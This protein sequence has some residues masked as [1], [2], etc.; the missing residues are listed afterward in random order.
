[1]NLK[2]Y[3]LLTTGFL[4]LSSGADK[5]DSELADG[6]INAPLS[7]VWRIFTTEEGY[8][9][10]GVNQVDIDLK[11]G[12]HIRTHS[13]PGA[14][15]DAETMDKEILAYDPEHMLALRTAQAPASLPH[16]DALQGTWTVTYFEN[17]GENMTRVRVVGVG[18]GNDAQ[19][20]ALQEELRQSNRELIDRVGKRYWPKCAHCQLESP[21]APAQ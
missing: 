8:K 10:A 11:I 20:Q 5:A 15:G 17:A 14:L 9:G 16:R 6:F 21:L 19:S 18:F 2:I 13:G 3:A 12:G 7:E 1:M 4:A